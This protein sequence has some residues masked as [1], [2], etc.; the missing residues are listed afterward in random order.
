MHAALQFFR[1]SKEHGNAAVRVG[2]RRIEPRIVATI[3][4]EAQMFDF[5][6]GATSRQ[7]TDVTIELHA[8]DVDRLKKGWAAVIPSVSK[9]RVRMELYPPIR[10]VDIYTKTQ[11]FGDVIAVFKTNVAGEAEPSLYHLV[12]LKDPPALPPPDPAQSGTP[13]K[14]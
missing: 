1:P 3:P 6:D 8:Q 9:Q 10:P 11:I 13:T 4:G 5:D 2:T 7:I 12:R 14:S